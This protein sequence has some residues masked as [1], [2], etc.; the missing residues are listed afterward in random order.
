[1]T[2]RSF[3]PVTPKHFSFNSPAGA[4]ATCH[5]LGQK[6]VFDPALVVPDDSKSLEEGAV[7]PW[8]RGGKRMVV[9]YK[10]MIKSVA[11]HYG[12]SLQVPWKS[13]PEE[14]RR[15]LLGGSGETEVEFAFLRAGKASAILRPFEGVLPNLQRL[16]VES[17]SE[18]TKNRL[19]AF[20]NP[21]P[22]DVCGG[23][24]LKPEMLAVTL[25]DAPPA[26]PPG[27]GP[28]IPGLSIMD[29]C[30][31]SIERADD[32]LAGLRLTDYQLKIAGEIIKEIRSRL[33]FLKNV[34]LGYLTLNRE[35]G[36]L[37]GGEAQRIRL[38]TQIGAGAG[39]RPLHPGRAEHR[40]APAGQRAAP[41]DPRRTA[42][43]GQQRPGRRARRGHHPPGRLHRRPGAWRRRAWRRGGRP[44]V[45]G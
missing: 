11:A 3:E 32:F 14:F 2:G 13:L 38:A 20:M 10:A 41:Q 12:A 4:C 30:E 19:K 44:G 28:V 24:R 37:S 15:I 22:C 36:T 27:P 29:L 43:P 40:P 7:L 42:R 5:G 25:G 45:G 35:S 16:Y 18:F 9:Y 31:L 33:G 1:M 8:R 39:G 21:C 26:R 23:R 34:G 17:E 6:M